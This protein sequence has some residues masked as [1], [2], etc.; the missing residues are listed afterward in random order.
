MDKK[1]SLARA[2]QIIVMFL[3]VII[4]LLAW[5]TKIIRIQDVSSK[6]DILFECSE[7]IYGR[8]EFMQKF[9]PQYRELDNIYLYI[10]NELDEQNDVSF[11]FYIFNEELEA[12]TNQEIF[13]EGSTYPGYCK[14]PINEIFD[15]EIEYHFLLSSPYTPITIGYS[16]KEE[17]KVKENIV[18]Y[19]G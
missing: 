9:E 15:P 17:T 12:I 7:E 14:I 4:F 13:L 18:A 3:A 10:E 8:V 5:P 2:V 1:I 19:L 16:S 6:Q 11:Q